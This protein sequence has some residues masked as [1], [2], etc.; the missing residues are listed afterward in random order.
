MRV[1]AALAMVASL[2]SA[3]VAA[4]ASDPGVRFT[5][6]PTGWHAADGYALSWRSRP[7]AGGW[8]AGMPRNGIAVTVIFLRKRVGYPP[9][10]LTLPK[11]PTG[12]LEG[13]PKTRVYLIVGRSRGR[14]VEVRAAI[15]NVNPTPAQLQQ[16]QRVVSGIR[17]I[18]AP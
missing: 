1:L 5:A 12:P 10:R 16:A 4:S 18:P 14:D 6:L 8:A 9:L 17:L 7:T 15:R 13:V 2:S 11:R 3:G